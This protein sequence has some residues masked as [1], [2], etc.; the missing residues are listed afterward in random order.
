M[1]A[2]IF[3]FAIGGASGSLLTWFYSRIPTEQTNH[4]N[5][6]TS[7]A[8]NNLRFF[9]TPSEDKDM[10]IQAMLRL[11]SYHQVDQQKNT[12]LAFEYYLKAAKLGSAEALPP[13]ERLVEELGVE[14][15]SQLVELYQHYLPN[16]ER[17]KHW[18]DTINM[19]QAD[20]STNQ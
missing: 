7:N 18:E 8:E 3:I 14:E 11:G 17:A 5:R 4:P 19:L 13:L 10:A 9:T 15:M 16:E 12:N 6:P 1:V 2:P 20:T